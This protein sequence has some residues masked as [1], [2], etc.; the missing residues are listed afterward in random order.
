M[1]V[2][3]KKQIFQKIE[4]NKEKILRF[5]VARIGLFGSFVRNKQKAKSDIDLLVNFLGEK[6]TFR[7]YMNFIH[8]MEKLLQRKVEVLTP[9]SLSPYIAPYIQ[10]ETEYVEISS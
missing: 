10:R 1:G 8:F 2:Q 3:S 6:K 4:K 5:G 9:E 7:N